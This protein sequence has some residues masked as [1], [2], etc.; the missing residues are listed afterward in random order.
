MMYEMMR[1]ERGGSGVERKIY[2]FEEYYY[3]IIY[4]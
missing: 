4:S 3:F 1:L 2:I